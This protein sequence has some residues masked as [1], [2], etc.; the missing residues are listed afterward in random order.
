MRSLTSATRPIIATSSGRL[1]VDAPHEFLDFAVA[2]FWESIFTE[3]RVA[4]KS[5]GIAA[6]GFLYP[7]DAFCSRKL[8]LGVEKDF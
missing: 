8:R 7:V 2:Q 6:K 3:S 5:S 1:I 4:G